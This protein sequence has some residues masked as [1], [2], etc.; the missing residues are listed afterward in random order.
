MQ[1]TFQCYRCGARNY[2]GT[3][4]CWHCGI[5][6]T[7]QTTQS[8]PIYQQPVNYQQQS[9]SFYQQQ[10]TSG[11]GDQAIIPDEIRHWNWG[12]L[13][14]NVLWGI[15]NNTWIALLTVIPFVGFVMIFVLGAKGN[16]W[17]WRNKG[18]ESIESFQRTQ[19]A[20][21]YWGIGLCILQVIALLGFLYWAH[22]QG[23]LKYWALPKGYLENFK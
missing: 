22:S 23:S 20:W 11:S 15:C 16:E 21:M 9:S 13:L 17:A 8:P 19:R 14:L 5:T 18:W 4:S 3:Q 12:A 1:Q 7:W 10:S 6:F 2:V